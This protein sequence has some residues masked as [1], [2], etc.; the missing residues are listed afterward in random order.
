MAC[1]KDD[2]LCTQAEVPKARF[3]YH[4]QIMIARQTNKVKFTQ[5]VNTFIR[6]GSITNYIPQTPDLLE[7]TRI[8][9][10][11]LQRGKI[12]MNIGDQQNMH[13]GCQ[14]HYNVLH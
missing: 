8:M 9:D 7:I 4:G 3:T 10:D 11:S 14:N 1:P 12:G 6:F 13:I 2:L 5:T